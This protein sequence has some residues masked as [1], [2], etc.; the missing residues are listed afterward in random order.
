LSVISAAA[1]YRYAWNGRGWLYCEERLTTEEY[2]ADTLRHQ[3][4]TGERNECTPDLPVVPDA[5]NAGSS[6]FDRHH[7]Y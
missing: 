2:S 1:L 3:I 5:T 4:K 6:P 7:H